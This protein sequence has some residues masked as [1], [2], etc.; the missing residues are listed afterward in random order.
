MKTDDGQPA[1]DGQPVGQASQRVLQRGQ[2]MIDRD[3]QRLKRTRGGINSM[4]RRDRHTGT[5]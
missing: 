4:V 1:P 3:P 2:L 5:N